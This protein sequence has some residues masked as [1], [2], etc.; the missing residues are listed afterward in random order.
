M[1]I[2]ISNGEIT[3]KLSILQIKKDNINNEDKLKNIIKEFNYLYNIVFN[4]L[5]IDL[6][7]YNNLLI[8]NKKLWDIEDNIRNKERNKEFDSEFIELAR[9]VYITNDE[10]SEVKKLINLKTNSNFVEEKSYEKY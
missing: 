7:D 5:N 10:R 6:N 2:E 9:L 4:D 1:K 8:I 3:D